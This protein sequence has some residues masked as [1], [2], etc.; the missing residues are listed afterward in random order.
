MYKQKININLENCD[1]SGKYCFKFFNLMKSKK[2]DKYCH[3]ILE[4]LSSL[5]FQGLFFSIFLQIFENQNFRKWKMHFKKITNSIAILKKKK[6]PEL[7]DESIESM[8]QQIL[9]EKQKCAELMKGN[10]FLI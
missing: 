10:I 4:N 2:S 6:N 3:S 5:L 9:E 1:E 8:E 7:I